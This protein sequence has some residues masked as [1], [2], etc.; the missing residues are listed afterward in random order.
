MPGHI[1]RRRALQIAGG[2]LAVGAGAA[3]T[4]QWL[5][6]APEATE[7]GARRFVQARA[8][9]SGNE[10]FLHIMAH[11]DDNL[12]FMNPELE[13][14]ILSGAPSVT[15]CM[16]G[17]ES[18]GNN[19]Q[20]GPELPEKRPEFVRAR[21]NGLR[22]ATAQMATGDPESPWELEALSLIPGFQVELHTLTA[23]PQV[24][25]IFMGLCEARTIQYAPPNCMRGLWLGAVPTLSTLLPTRSP[26]KKTYQY[27]HG[28]VIDTLTAV[29]E[30]Y[31]PSV[32]RTLDP[33]PSHLPYWERSPF[34]TAPGVLKGI[35][36]HDHQDHTA[37]ALYTQMALTRYWSKEHARPTAVETY[38]GYETTS[39]SLPWNL[40]TNAIDRKVDYL[41]TYGWADKA[42]CGDAAG[43]GDLKVGKRPATGQRWSHHCRTRATGTARWIATLPDGRLT[44]FSLLN[45]AAQCWTETTAGSG[46]WTGP[47]SVGGDLPKDQVLEGQIQV[48]RR[49]DGKLQLFAVR[50][51]VPSTA[52]KY[53]Q[54]EVVT[55]LQTNPGSGGAPAFGPWDSLGSPESDAARSLEVGY[56]VAVVDEKGNFSVFVR[57]WD[58][59]ISFRTSSDGKNWSRWQQLASPNGRRIEDGL[60]AAVD[61][62]GRMHLVAYSYAYGYTVTKDDKGKDKFEIQVSDKTVTHWMSPSAGE[63]PRLMD[64]TGLPLVTGELT[65][66]PLSDGGMRMVSRQAD[67]ARVM[68]CDRPADGSWKQTALTDAIGGFGRAAVSVEKDGTTVLAARDAKGRVRLSVGQGRPGTWLD[69]GINHRATPG[70]TQDAQGRT[71]VVVIGPDGKISS[72]RHTGTGFTGWIGQDGTNQTNAMA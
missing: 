15:V 30:R 51:T 47:A 31:Q 11:E 26:L 22:R 59:K 68:V 29:L 60:D 38:L 43:C 37:S 61:A 3:G 34:N 13:Q 39:L 16:T 8:K 50:R 1:S 70:V 49:P 57:N 69:G 46:Q 20:D 41:L 53:Q 58:E 6:P 18:N 28:D 10:S 25:L 40:D 62:K 9:G 23:A 4:W 56:P 45:G 64:P 21:T 12:F 17:G 7:S 36:S 48:V 55:A 35:A 24:Q 5:A 71:V 19:S 44:A 42:D 72:A 63:T 32:V 14:S 65:L 54:Q 2:G 66:V 33:N 67:T 52:G 27:K